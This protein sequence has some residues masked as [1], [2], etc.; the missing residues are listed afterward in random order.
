MALVL[1]QLAVFGAR[2]AAATGGDLIADVMVNEPYPDYVA[3]S[4]AFDG[5]YLYH[6]GQAGRLGP[7]G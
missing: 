5:R 1:M 2:P 7:Y 4:V 6:T 3:P